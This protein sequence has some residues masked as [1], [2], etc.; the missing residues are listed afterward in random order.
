MSSRIW[1]FSDSCDRFLIVSEFEAE[2]LVPPPIGTDQLPRLPWSLADDETRNYRM[3]VFDITVQ[4]FAM[5]LQQQFGSF[6]IKF[7]DGLNRTLFERM[8]RRIRPSGPAQPPSQ[9]LRTG[10]GACRDLS[11]LFMEVCR[12]LGMPSRFV[13]GYQASHDTPD[14]RRHLHAW[15]EVFLPQQGWCGWDPMHGVR[16]T[17]AHIALCHAPDQAGTMPVTGGFTFQGAVVS[18]T[19]DYRIMIRCP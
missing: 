18:S 11:A 8:D 19:L 5:D 14:Q 12:A 13:S 15:V 16:V 2:S 17:D 9:T 1:V 10:V 3:D 6:P 4:R 7:L